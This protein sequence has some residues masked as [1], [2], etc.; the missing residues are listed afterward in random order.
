MNG[1]QHAVARQ[2]TFPILVDGKVF[3]CPDSTAAWPAW[4]ADHIG[5]EA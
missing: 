3:L 4:R 2:P 1:P 5:S